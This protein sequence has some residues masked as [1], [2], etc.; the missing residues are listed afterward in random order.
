MIS[1]PEELW[2]VAQQRWTCWM[3]AVSDL[4]KRW[5]DNR[6]TRT[7]SRTES[8]HVSHNPLISIPWHWKAW[9]R[10][11]IYNH[12]A[13]SGTHN[14]L[15]TSTAVTN[16]FCTISEKKKWR[17]PA[18]ICDR[19]HP[20]SLTPRPQGFPL[21]FSIGTESHDSRMMRLP[22]GCVQF[23]IGWAVLYKPPYDIHPATC[24]ANHPRCHSNY[25][26]MLGVAQVKRNITHTKAV[27][28]RNL[29][30]KYRQHYKYTVWTNGFITTDTN[31][32][33]T[34]MSLSHFRPLV[35]ISY[36]PNNPG[37][38]SCKQTLTTAV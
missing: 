20:V 27:V 11:L 16:G 17:F 8:G 36:W 12:T 34:Q 10:S 32:H 7:M 21:E 28:Y 38:R 37:I 35:H 2:S 4:H 25:Y 33:K 1:H 30:C 15:P 6:R 19:S 14:L 26:A 22:D 31:V 29:H 24:P 3:T 13:R 9:K 23:K 18:E 5:A